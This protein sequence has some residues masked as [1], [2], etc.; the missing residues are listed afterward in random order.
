MPHTYK[1][2][3]EAFAATILDGVPQVGANLDDGLAAMQAMVA[4]A[5]SAESGE[6]VRLADVTRRRLMHLGIFAKTF[7]RPTFEETLDAIADRGITHVQFNMSC[8]GLPTLPERI[9][10][11]PVRLDRPLVPRARP[12]DGRDLGDVQ[13]LRSGC[14]PARREPPSARRPGRRPADGSTRGSSRSARARAT[15]TTC[16]DGIP[17]TC[18]GPPGTVLIA[19]MRPAAEIADR[20]EVTLAFEPERKTW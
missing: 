13:S 20:H 17:R 14:S 11:G 1:R 3:V 2:Q 16:G 9:G 10:G 19:S 6:L 5:R 4:I 15:P 7:P 12:D 8:A 18:A